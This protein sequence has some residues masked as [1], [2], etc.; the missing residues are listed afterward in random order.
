MAAKTRVRRVWL[1]RLPEIRAARARTGVTIPAM[2]ADLGLKRWQLAHTL[3]GIKTSVTMPAKVA[4]YFEVPVGEL[5]YVVD[6]EHLPKQ[7]PD[8]AEA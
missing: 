4:A 1:P 2:A 6:L 5:F 8:A 3:N 7:A